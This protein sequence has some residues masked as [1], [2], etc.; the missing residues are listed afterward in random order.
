MIRACDRVLSTEQEN[1]IIH[2]KPQIHQAKP[3]IKHN[4]KKN[5]QMKQEINHILH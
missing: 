3:D 2:A 1:I 4:R 5:S